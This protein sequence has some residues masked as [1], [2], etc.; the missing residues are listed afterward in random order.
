MY[1]AHGRKRISKREQHIHFDLTGRGRKHTPIGA[2]K[3]I[4]QNINTDYFW[5]QITGDFWLFFLLFGF[6]QVFFLQ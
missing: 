2:W 1:T 5:E 3:D 6:S 4:H